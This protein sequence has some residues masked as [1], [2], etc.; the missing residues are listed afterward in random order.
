MTTMGLD[1]GLLRDKEMLD[2]Q[3]SGPSMILVARPSGT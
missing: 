3:D 1:Y 2:D